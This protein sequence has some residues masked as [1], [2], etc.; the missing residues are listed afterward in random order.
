M[1][2][3]CIKYYHENYGGMLQAYATTK[4]IEKMGYNYEII[5]YEKKK[6][7]SFMIKSIP[8]IFNNILLN[9]KYEAFQK[10]ISFKRHPEFSENDKIRM[11]AFDKFRKEKFEN[12]LSKVYVGYE[13]LCENSKKYSCVVTGSDQLWSPAGLPTNFYNLKFVDNS[14]KK[15]SYAS[16]FGVS[17]IPWY[18]KKRTA[19]FLNRI[20]YISVRENSGKKIIKELINKDVPVVLD[21]VFMFDSKEW[22]ELIPERKLFDGKYIFAYFLGSNIEHRRVVEELALKTGYK[23]VTLRHLDQYVE[24]DEKFGDYAPYNVSPADFL[25]ILRGAEYVCTDSYHGSVFSIINEKKFVVFNRYNNNSKHSKNSRIETLC[26]NLKINNTRYD[27]NINKILE[28]KIDYKKV[29][30]ELDKLKK[31]SNDYLK[32]A[33]K[34]LNEG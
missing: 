19:D 12:R 3:L 22:K 6:N 24:F 9:D 15:V 32:T 11:D 33:L 13:N 21:P 23:I 29:N 5:R 20:D 26:S 4:I 31:V 7:I 17:Y 8:R 34:D 27:G 14:I 1:I 25:N 30:K 28:N 16:S 2:G 10:K 18:Q